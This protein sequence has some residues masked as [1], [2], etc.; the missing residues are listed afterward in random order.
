ME[1]FMHLR[2]K[3]EALFIFGAICLVLAFIFIGFSFISDLQ[4]KGVN[5]WYKPIKF[6]LSIGIYA[7]TMAYFSSHLEGGRHISIFNWVIIISL[8]FEIL[9]IAIQ[10]GRGQ[11]S[12]YN[13]SSPFYV[14]LYV[15]MAVAATIA[16][17]ATAYI[18]VLF[19]KN[20]FPQLSETYLWSIRL[21]IL[22]FVIFSLEGFVMGSRLSHTIGGEDG[23]PGLKFLGWSTRHGDPRIAHFIGMHALQ[24]LPLL[25]AFLLKD[26]WMIILVSLL[27][28][29]L[30]FYVLYL[31]FQG[32]PP[33]LL[34]SPLL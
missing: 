34:E 16:T 1:F 19:F 2:A 17:I 33:S 20:N 7:W 12:H 26:L 8:G 29:G 30:A 22:L 13:M 32:Q 3:N 18:G 11:L 14:F 6:A 27:Y 10:A 5:A 24:V 23:G 21:G 9:Y 25:A 4:V 31:A 15:L 28:G